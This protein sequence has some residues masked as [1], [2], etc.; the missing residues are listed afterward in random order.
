MTEN[1]ALPV[2]TLDAFVIG[3]GPAGLMAAQALL[4]AGRA[5]V[6]A[7]AKP[8]V[9]RKFLMAGKSGLNLTKDEPFEAFMAA[10]L[11]D[12]AHLRPM[13]AQFGP[14]QV[15]DWAESLGQTLFTGSSGRVFPTVMKASPLLRQ[16]MAQLQA[17]GLD[18]RV[19]HRW[20]GWNGDST[21]LDGP[22]GP[23]LANAKVTILALGGGSWARLGSDGAWRTYFEGEGIRLVPFAPS[24]AGLQI[25]WSQHMTAHF[26]APLKNT[27][28]KAGDLTSRGEA[29]ISSRGFE[30]GGIY[31]LGPALRDGASLK[32][33]LLPD[34]TG[35]ALTAKLAKPRGKQSLSNHLRKVT[36]LSPA[37]LA[38]INE[39]A[40]PLPNDPAALAHLLKNLTVPHNGLRPLDE[41]ISTAGGV[42]FDELTPDLM[43]KKRPGTYCVGEMLDWDAPTG[44]YLL[45]ACLATG[46]WAGQRAAKA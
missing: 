29:V 16:W 5:V 3:G 30:G 17:Q 45:T 31:P 26:G 13:I 34:Q 19:G 24:N 37:T 42:P 35:Q 21:C 40:R 28:F 27:V 44:G 7:E 20:I 12:A 6:L 1:T 18:L 33:D 2:Q 41:A 14:Q 22:D 32:L 4:D 11:G 25:T 36:R 39:V 9:G 10:Y 23:Y 15:K 38:L 46:L 8:T 43:L